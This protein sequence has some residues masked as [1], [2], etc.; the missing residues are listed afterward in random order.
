MRREATALAIFVSASWACGGTIRPDVSG[1]PDAATT[2]APNAGPADATTGDAPRDA[3]AGDSNDAGP[4]RVPINHR[5]NDAQCLSARPDSGCSFGDCTPE[6]CADAGANPL[7]VET[8]E[9]CCTCTF[10]ACSA[11]SDCPSAQTCACHGSAYTGGVGNT[12]VPGNCRVDADCGV[13]GYCSPSPAM[14]CFGVAGYYC[15]TAKDQCESDSDCPPA[16]GGASSPVC[17]YSTTNGTWA[18]QYNPD[19]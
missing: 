11:D 6:T 3:H 18:C 2:D 1:S 8:C 5:P 7:C 17:A 15:H 10:D 9:D 16:D 12:C 13:N 19:C 14:G 4:N